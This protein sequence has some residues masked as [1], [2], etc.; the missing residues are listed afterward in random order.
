MTHCEVGF[1]DKVLKAYETIT[2][3]ANSLSHRMQNG[4]Q[5]VH[6]WTCV[7]IDCG[8]M[9]Y[10][11]MIWYGLQVIHWLSQFSSLSGHHHSGIYMYLPD[12]LIG[13]LEI[14]M[15][16]EMISSQLD[17]SA[18]FLM[19]FS[20]NCH[21]CNV[22]V[23]YWGLNNIGSGN[24]LVSSGNKLLLERMLTKCCVAIWPQ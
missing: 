15:T 16:S 1:K 7:F 8:G 10:G 24:G 14:W 18:W 13:P 17:I 4:C 22:T 5:I 3:I 6:N 11:F 23:P 9:W 20:L 19:C 2:K 12:W 21:Q